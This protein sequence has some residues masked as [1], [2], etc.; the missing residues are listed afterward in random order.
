MLEP[1][2]EENEQ[3]PS[4]TIIVDA[5]TGQPAADVNSFSVTHDGVPVSH[6]ALDL[7][8]VTFKSDGDGFFASL[9]LGADI[10]LV[11][12]SLRDA[13]LMVRQRA[14]SAPSLSP[15]GARIA[16][17]GL[18]SSDGPTWRLHVLDLATLM[19]TELAE[20]TSVDDQMAW[21]DD[22]HVL[23]GLNSD[24]WSLNS[25]GTGTPQPFLFDG[26]SASVVRQ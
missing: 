3:P 19:D 5:K 24:T 20:R 17:D 4:R 6:E 11:E 10:Y 7:W 25:D 23:Y 9:R 26:L 22:D 21:L 18:V 16:Y 8:G 14:V 13:T 2:S 12:G 15:D 1:K